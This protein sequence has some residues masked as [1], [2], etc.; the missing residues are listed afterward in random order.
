MSQPRPNAPGARP[1]TASRAVGLYGLYAI[2]FALGGGIG[3]GVPAVL[4][5]LVTG[6]DFSSGEGVYLYAIMFGVMGFIAYRL[7]QRVAEG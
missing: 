2:V 4:V 1:L 7:A 5:R 3:A 6:D